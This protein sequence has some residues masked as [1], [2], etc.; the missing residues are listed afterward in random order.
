[1]ANTIWQRITHKLWE[2]DAELGDDCPDPDPDKELV[3][4]F[5]S[6][7]TPAER[8]EYTMT[9]LLSEVRSELADIREDG[10]TCEAHLKEYRDERNAAAGD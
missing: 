10:C 9:S 7:L 5:L 8:K 2:I 1:M 4:A 3:T 6:R